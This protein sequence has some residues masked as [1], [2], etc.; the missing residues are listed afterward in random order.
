MRAINNFKTNEWAEKA[1]KEQIEKAEILRELEGTISILNNDR[2]NE[3]LKFA[4]IL[5]RAQ[6]MELKTELES[7]VELTDY[8]KKKLEILKR[9]LGET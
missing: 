4:K 2:I 5:E 9:E 3:L 6:K 8:G 1:R 7:A